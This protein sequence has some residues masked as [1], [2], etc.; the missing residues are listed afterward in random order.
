MISIR[1]KEV[2]EI[3]GHKSKTSNN[4]FVKIDSK[5]DSGVHASEAGSANQV[6]TSYMRLAM[7]VTVC[8]GVVG[9]SVVVINDRGRC[10]K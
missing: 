6:L 1:F 3:N 8:L 10:K 9:H 7:F 4:N 5:V 2:I